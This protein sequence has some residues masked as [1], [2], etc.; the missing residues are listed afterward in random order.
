MPTHTPNSAAS[1]SLTPAASSSLTPSHQPPP[2]LSLPPPLLPPLLR[3]LLH[4]VQPPLLPSFFFLHFPRLAVQTGPGTQQHQTYV[5]WWKGTLKPRPAVRVNW[6]L[7]R[8]V[9]VLFLVPT[10][11]FPPFPPPLL[12]SLPLYC[13]C[14]RHPSCC[15]APGWSCRLGQERSSTHRCELVEGHPQAPPRSQLVLRADERG[16]G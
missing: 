13:H 10:P 11:S 8:M 16:L 1:S 7:D 12:P 6:Y 4:L 3:Y 5:N 15:P 2:A 9:A 14:C